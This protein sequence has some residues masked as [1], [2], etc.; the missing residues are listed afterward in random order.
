LHTSRHTF[1]TLALSKGI[2]L[3]TVSK[4]LG[5]TNIT[6]TQVY[7]KILDTSKRKAV[8]LLPTFD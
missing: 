8:E 4:M 7:A 1:A 3:Y 6:Q 5:H 2:D